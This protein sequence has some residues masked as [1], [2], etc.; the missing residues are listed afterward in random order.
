MTAA[1]RRFC[2]RTWNESG[3]ERCKGGAAAVQY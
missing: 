1:A 2:S 3:I